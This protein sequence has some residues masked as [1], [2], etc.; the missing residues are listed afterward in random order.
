MILL[1]NQFVMGSVDKTLFIKK[2]DGHILVVQIYVDDI[3]FGSTCEQLSIE[4]SPTMK[5]EFEMSMEGELRFFPSL[6]IKQ[7]KDGIFD[8]HSKFARELVRKFGLKD[9]NPLNTPISTS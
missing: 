5:N 3:I 9:S 4:F 6:Q 8:N 2:N 7:P 1:E